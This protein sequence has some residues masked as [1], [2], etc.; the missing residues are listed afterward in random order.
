M[1]IGHNWM[2]GRAITPELIENIEDALFQFLQ[3]CSYDDRTAEQ[4]AHLF[5]DAIEKTH[6]LVPF[7]SGGRNAEIRT[8]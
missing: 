1:L 4:D 5:I 3:I 2:K 8:D 6:R 7:E